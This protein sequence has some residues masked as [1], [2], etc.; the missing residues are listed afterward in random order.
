MTLGGDEVVVKYAAYTRRSR[1][2]PYSSLATS[3]AVFGPLTTPRSG[4]PEIRRWAH[5]RERSQSHGGGMPGRLVPT[6]AACPRPI[7][8]LTSSDPVPG[9]ARDAPAA[10]TTPTAADHG[11]DGVDRRRSSRR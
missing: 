6:E 9:E 4:V 8:P 3:D 1:A 10:A 7:S 11:Q 5:A 2:A